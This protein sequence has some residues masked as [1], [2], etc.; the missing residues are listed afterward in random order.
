MPLLGGIAA[1]RLFSFGA[2]PFDARAI[3]EAAALAVKP[4]EVSV[5]IVDHLE[6]HYASGSQSDLSCHPLYGIAV[7]EPAD[8]LQ[9]F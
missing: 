6:P 7:F 9:I 8:Q 3:P 5:S 2:G 4:Y 1:K